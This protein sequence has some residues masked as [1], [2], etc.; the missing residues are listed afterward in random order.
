[1]KVSVSFLKSLYSKEETIQKLN[2]TSCDAIHVDLID[3]IYVKEEKNYD[4][5][6]MMHLLTLAKKPL[7]FHFMVENPTEEIECFSKLHPKCFILSFEIPHLV[8]MIEKVK[9]KKI[10]VGL[11]IHPDTPLE[12]VIPYLKDIDLVQVMS[13][14]PGKGGQTFMDSILSKLKDLYEYKKSNHLNFEITIDGGINDETKENV[15]DYVD[16]LVSGAYVC[17]SDNFENTIQKLKK[18]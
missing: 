9:E 1:M 7:E 6:E 3:G 10:L 17:M 15:K 14:I 4:M 16:E 11:A 8:S 18:V 13:V 5:E 12:K 2:Y